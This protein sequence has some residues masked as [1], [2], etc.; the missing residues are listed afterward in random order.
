MTSGSFYK[1]FLSLALAVI[2]LTVPNNLSS[3]SFEDSGIVLGGA[4]RGEISWC[5]YDSDHDLD[6]LITGRGEGE[7]Q[8]TALYRNDE[9]QF[10]YAEHPFIPV[11]ESMAAWGD[12]DNDSD[13]DLLLAGTS[14]YG[15]ITLIYNNNGGVF[16]GI[17]AGLPGIHDGTVTWIDTDNDNDLDIF[18]SGN[19]IT[20]IFINED[21]VFT[22]AGQNFGYFSG[23]SADFG[24]YDND[25]DKDL[26][27]NGDSGAG[28]VTK[29]FTNDQGVFT[30]SGLIFPGLMAGTADFID[31]DN[32]GDLD[33]AYS[34]NNDALEA[35][36]YLYKKRGSDFEIV[37]SG[38]D[39]F[40]LGACDW[41]DYDDDGDPDLI[42]SGKATGCGAYVSG[43]YRN[44]GNDFFT[45]ISQQFTTATRCSISWTDVENDGDLDFLISG[46]N[47]SESP[48][49][50]IYLNTG[51]DNGYSPNSNPSVPDGLSSVSEGNDM[52][53]SWLPSFDYES[54]AEGLFY[55]LRLGTS[56][57]AYDII[58]PGSLADGS[59]LKPDRGNAG[60]GTSCKISGL[61]PGTY[62]WSVQTID[63][64]LESSAFSGEQ[65]F[66]I[67]ATGIPENNL[68]PLKIYPN[69][70]K[71]FVTITQTSDN[72]GTDLLITDLAGKVII[73]R[74][75]SNETESLD[76][77][78]LQPGNYFVVLRHNGKTL[79]R[80]L[81][82]SQ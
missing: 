27:I 56:P 70:A 79:S 9:G 22:D 10:N 39:G 51:G 36:F 64:I 25:G 81:T 46:L 58:S 69:P 32:D 76:I 66:T 33:V 74:E 12:Y 17:E 13:Q 38:I 7:W 43:I 49:A 75:V 3:Q 19:W 82:I 1:S 54:P 34:G 68:S 42:M 35:R 37:Y 71:D 18:L 48:F 2:S 29:I 52:L 53:L 47:I 21:G 44:E 57:G 40:A 61:E 16:S 65:S 14:A 11:E 60:Q 50:K 26:L 55:N 78:I 28:A 30:D 73:S 5:D 63:R 6:L 45:K 67:T 24:D 41:D 80:V 15:D 4:G 8:M 31:F 59:R 20:E 72:I 23:T 62:Y 77:G